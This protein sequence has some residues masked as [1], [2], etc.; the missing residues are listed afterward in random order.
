[1]ALHLNTVNKYFFVCVQSNIVAPMTIISVL[2]E[3][4]VL[5]SITLNILVI[6]GDIGIVK[7][8]LTLLCKLAF[9]ST[10]SSQLGHKGQHRLIKRVMEHTV[11]ELESNPP[12]CLHDKA[13]FLELP[14]GGS[15]ASENWLVIVRCRQCS[16]FP[17][18]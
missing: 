14:E 9:I 2:A 11:I 10:H 3:P 8:K 1:M 6:F 5:V 18:K 13:M 15:K 4:S 7:Q 16:V 12:L 17:L